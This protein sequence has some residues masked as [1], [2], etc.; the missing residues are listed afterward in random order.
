MSRVLAVLIVIATCLVALSVSAERVPPAAALAQVE[1][2]EILPLEEFSPSLLGMFRKVMELQP[3]HIEANRELRLANMRR[4]K[5]QG[6]GSGGG[7]FGFT[8]KK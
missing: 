1:E 6:E 4:G 8:R 3:N 2:G 5:G 7:L